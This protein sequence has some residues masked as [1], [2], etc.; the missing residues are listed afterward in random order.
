MK[1]IIKQ[2][3]NTSNKYNHKIHSLNDIY[4][5]TERENT[6]QG[7][8]ILCPLPQSPPEILRAVD[9]GVDGLAKTLRG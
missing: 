3:L 8:V 1:Y 5:S 6:N 2:S 7:G 9:G 4:M